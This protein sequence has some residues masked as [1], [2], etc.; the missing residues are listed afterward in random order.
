[1]KNKQLL[2]CLNFS[3]NLQIIKEMKKKKEKEKDIIANYKITY[4]LHL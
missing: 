2:K 1:M 3:D 4:S